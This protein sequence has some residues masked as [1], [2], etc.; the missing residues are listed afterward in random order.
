MKG[1]RFV[2]FRVTSWIVPKRLGQ[3]IH[4]LTRKSTKSAFCAEPS[5]SICGLLQRKR[6]HSYSPKT[7]R[8][9]VSGNKLFE[10]LP[11]GVTRGFTASGLRLGICISTGLTLVSVGWLDVRA[12]G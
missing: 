5:G 11:A 12:S 8:G 6:T 1:D 7:R 10:G 9:L 4:E 3:A 2:E